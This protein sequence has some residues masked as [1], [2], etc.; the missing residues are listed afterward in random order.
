MIVKVQHMGL[1]R[2]IKKRWGRKSRF[3][4]ETGEAGGERGC[5]TEGKV[6]KGRG[7][8]ETGRSGSCHFHIW[9]L[10]PWLCLIMSSVFSSSHSTF[11]PP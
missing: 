4:R 1:D 8:A 9:H 7:Q 6:G 11:P 2:N 10:H 5:G 3:G